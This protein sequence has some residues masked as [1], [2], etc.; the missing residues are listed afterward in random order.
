MAQNNNS[1]LHPKESTPHVTQRVKIVDREMN[2]RELNCVEDISSFERD[3][4]V[5]FH[6]IC[7]EFICAILQK[8]K[9][10]NL[11]QALTAGLVDLTALSIYLEYCADSIIKGYTSV[12]P[13]YGGID[14]SRVGI[15]TVYDRNLKD[16][17]CK[18]SFF[19][20]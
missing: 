7:L 20:G 15:H 6:D 16:V 3:F 19:R 1:Y 18:I 13:Q 17:V 4:L 9:I 10:S 2:E 14:L 11:E 5:A 8:Q 12:F